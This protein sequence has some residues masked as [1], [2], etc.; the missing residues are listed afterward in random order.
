M[1]CLI[2]KPNCILTAQINAGLL[3]AMPQRVA[4]D[5]PLVYYNTA[6]VIIGTINE[7]PELLDTNYVYLIL[8]NSYLAK[9]LPYNWFNIFKLLNHFWDD[10][11]THNTPILTGTE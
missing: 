6:I 10:Y 9:Q 11:S 2:Y 5:L 4:I 7:D 1:T 3:F 8:A